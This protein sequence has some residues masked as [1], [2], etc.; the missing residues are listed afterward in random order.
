MVNVSNEVHGTGEYSNDL[1]GLVF[2]GN[3]PFLGGNA[4]FTN[5]SGRFEQFLSIGGGIHDRKTK[6]FLTLNAILPQQ[7]FELSVNRGSVAFSESGD[8]IDLRFEGEVLRANS[9]AYFKGMRS[10][11]RRVGKE[12]RSGWWM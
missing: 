4:S 8:Q 3:T 7:F 11:E 9:Y 1:F 5:T 12:G 10:E 2:I 6:S